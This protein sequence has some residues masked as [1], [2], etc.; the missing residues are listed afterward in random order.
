MITLYGAPNTR[1][2]RA[3]WMLEE[4]QQEYDY[5]A[6]DF[7]KGDSQSPDYLALNPAGKIPALIDNDLTLTESAAILTYLGDKFPDKQLV[8]TAGTIARGQYE[9]W[10]YFA[11]SEFEQPL[12]TMAKHKFAL[13]KPQRVAA[14]IPTAEW[15]FQKALAILSTGLGDRDFILG[16]EFSAA[17]ILLGQTLI[18]AKAF[19]QPI[20]QANITDYSARLNTRP[21]L[22]K[23]IA[24]ESGN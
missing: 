20:N 4:L 13:P 2:L 23:A 19:A 8:P 1:S 22:A 7:S 18:W 12:W 21:A 11:L 15:E 5:R 9:Q 3:S 10:C 17:D 14:I 24:K 6:I 16:S